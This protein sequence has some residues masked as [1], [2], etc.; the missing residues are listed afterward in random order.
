MSK[1]LVV[2][3]LDIVEE[4]RDDLVH[5]LGVPDIFSQVLVHNF[6]YHT[7]Q[8]LENTENHMIDL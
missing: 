2:L 6:P 4:G 8:T 5:V 3:Y 7:S 1:Y